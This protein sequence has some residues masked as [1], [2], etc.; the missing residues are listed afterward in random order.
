MPALKHL[1]L[2]Q[3]LLKFLLLKLHLLKNQQLLK[4][5]PHPLKLKIWKL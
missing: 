2:Q 4:K 5:K 3:A 1:L